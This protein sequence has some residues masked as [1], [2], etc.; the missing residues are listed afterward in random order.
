MSKIKKIVETI[1]DLSIYRGRYKDGYRDLMKALG[2]AEP[3]SKAQ[4]EEITGY[5]EPF[6]IDILSKKAFDI[7]WFDVYN[8]TNVFGFDLKKYVPDSY[9][10]AIIDTFFSNAKKAKVLDNKNYYDLYFPEAPRPKT[11]VHKANGVYL[12]EKYRLMSENDAVDCCY[13]ASKV[14]V[15]K[16]VDSSGGHG[17]IVWDRDKANKD[18]LREML[19]KNNSMVVQDYVKQHKVLSSFNDTCVNTIRMV[20]LYFEG[21]IHL[22]TAVVIM[23]GKDA[24]TNHLHRGGLVCG[25]LPSGQ[26]RKT[27]F[28]GKLNQYDVHP[29][30]ISF[31]DTILPNYD[32]CIDLVK[33]LAPRFVDN[34]RLIAWDLTIDSEANPVLIETNLSWGGSVQIAGGPVFGDL[35]D[36][37][38]E[39]VRVNRKKGLC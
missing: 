15:K 20:T 29:N 34:S 21:V 4:R 2:A 7:R 16:A 31:A 22:V 27:A 33:G 3:V 26:L 6:L 35:T 11:I 28:D 14:I 17:V 25:V 8:R 39:Y 10:Y 38:L 1:E 24:V 5:W 9:Y 13:E 12:D 32:K 37:V 23:G 36:E 18:E 30:G 19:R